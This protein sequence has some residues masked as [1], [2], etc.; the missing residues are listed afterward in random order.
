VSRRRR[1]Q[2]ISGSPPVPAR[3]VGRQRFSLGE[4]WTAWRRAKNPVLGFV[5]V[6]GVLLLVLYG[7]TL[8]R[9]FRKELFPAYLTLNAR[10][11]SA[12][13]NVLGQ[14]T[15]VSGTSIQ[16]PGFAIDI[17][18]GCDAID[19]IILFCSAVVA[20]PMSWKKKILGLVLGAIVLALLNLVRIISLFFIGAYYP[21]AF[22][23]MHGEVWQALFILLALVFWAVWIQWAMAKE[24]ALRHAPA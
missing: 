18:R 10:V 20:F 22:D 16:K 8:T 9:A 14:S 12:V 24:T 23:M 15:A 11:S 2:S 4:R 5:L 6:F 13:L 7:L 1:L 17:R 3:P 19:P 21:S